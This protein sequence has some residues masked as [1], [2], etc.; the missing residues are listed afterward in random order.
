LH[1]TVRDRNQKIVFE[2][3]AL[4]PDGSI[5]GNDNDAD[6][7]RFEPHLSEIRTSDQVQIY[8]SIMADPNGVVTTGLL[9]AVRYVKDNQLL[10]RGFDKRT[11][12]PDIAVVG[13]AA[14]DP[15]F[16]DAGN[17]VRY[18]AKTRSP[19]QFGFGGAH[20]QASAAL[21]NAAG[22]FTVDAELLYQP[23]GY[24]WANNLKSYN[25]PEP[26][27][28]NAYYD[29]MTAATTMTMAHT[30]RTAPECPQSSKLQHRAPH[31]LL[32]IALPAPDSS[33]LD[34]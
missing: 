18:H 30:S 22:P 34:S 32:S 10:P 4:N 29:A 13:E 19:D 25:A 7:H 20:S 9:S 27:R 21:G 23:I 17:C 28:F 6:P 33:N 8:E 14:N 16:T 15:D 26:R 24:R 3:G 31:R 2:S 12:T 11:A 5:Q 1:V